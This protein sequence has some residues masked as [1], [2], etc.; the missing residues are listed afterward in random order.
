[1]WGDLQS[2]NATPSY[3]QLPCDR[4]QRIEKKRG[5]LLEVFLSQSTLEPNKM[6]PLKS[7]ATAQVGTGHAVQYLE[8][9]PT[10]DRKQAVTTG[11]TETTNHQ[12]MSPTK[13]GIPSLG[14]IPALL[15]TSLRSQSQER[16]LNLAGENSTMMTY[17]LMASQPVGWETSHL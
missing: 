16:M 4:T 1:M 6:N 12:D 17:Q 2:H 8:L 9:R 11:S 3:R 10:D 14:R 15:P 7:M 5:G 13:I